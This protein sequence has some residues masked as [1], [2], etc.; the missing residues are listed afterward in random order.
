MC[1]VPLYAGSRTDLP[2]NTVSIGYYGRNAEGFLTGPAD[3][4]YDHYLDEVIAKNLEGQFPGIQGLLASGTLHY[5]AEVANGVISREQN[6]II[7]TLLDVLADVNKVPAAQ[8]PI[9]L[10]AAARLSARLNVADFSNHEWK[11][12]RQELEKYHIHF[13]SSPSKGVILDNPTIHEAWE[14]YPDSQ[15]T[16]DAF[17]LDLKNAFGCRD[18]G[19]EYHVMIVKGRTFI[20]HHP[21]DP[22]DPWVNFVLGVT[23]ADWYA[24]AEF[25]DLQQENIL[26]KDDI[27]VGASPIVRK[28]AINYFL[29]AAIGAPHSDLG[30]AAAAAIKGLSAGLP[31]SEVA[32]VCWVQ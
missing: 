11:P 12:F 24:I 19:R 14:Q 18:G 30:K 6:K 1:L 26:S 2:S 10:L 13:V 29:K 7:K 3:D 32:Y 28:S 22:R 17:V 21:N 16:E 9:L 25:S 20:Q 23:F 31:P 27:N 5:T 8:R 15:W 4:G